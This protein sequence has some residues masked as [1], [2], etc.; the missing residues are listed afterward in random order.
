VF[1]RRREAWPLAP[2]TPHVGSHRVVPAGFG[3][4]GHPRHRRIDSPPPA[5]QQDDPEGHPHG[6][7]ETTRAAPSR[8]GWVGVIPPG[9][10]RNHLVGASGPRARRSPWG[11]GSPAA[12]QRRRGMTKGPHGERRCSVARAGVASKASACSHPLDKQK[13]A[14][15]LFKTRYSSQAAGQY[16]ARSHPRANKKGSRSE[17]QEPNTSPRDRES[18]RIRSAQ[19][20]H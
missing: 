7:C 6:Q 5:T 10:W 14:T 16:K 8:T 15:Q 1:A 3:E 13:N 4:I 18:P 11:V 12:A 2:P 9:G 19:D 17:R 20:S